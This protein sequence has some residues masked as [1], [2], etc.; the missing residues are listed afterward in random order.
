MPPAPAP[1]PSVSKKRSN[2]STTFPPR[3]ELFSDGKHVSCHIPEPCE[4]LEVEV[5]KCSL[6]TTLNVMAVAAQQHDVIF[7]KRQVRMQNHS[8]PVVHLH[9]SFPLVAHLTHIPVS[10]VDESQ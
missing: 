5:A 8:L 10:L 4:Y 7:I 3:A 1:E 6:P 2:C 9:P